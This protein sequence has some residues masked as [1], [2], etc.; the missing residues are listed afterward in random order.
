MAETGGRIMAEEKKKR[1][2]F[3]VRIGPLL[4][5]ILNKQKE[6]IKKVTYDCVPSSDWEAGEILAKKIIEKNLV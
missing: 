3:S 6:N 4:K 1:E 2:E 5:R